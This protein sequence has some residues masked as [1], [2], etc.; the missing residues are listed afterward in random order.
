MCIDE[1]TTA[2]VTKREQDTK[3]SVLDIGRAKTSSILEID[4]KQS[5]S[6]QVRR[7]AGASSKNAR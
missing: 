6:K 4:H 3:S 7:Q 1:S 5:Q 2:A